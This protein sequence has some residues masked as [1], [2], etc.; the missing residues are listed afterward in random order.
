MAAGLDDGLRLESK[1]QHSRT[2][3]ENHR[4]LWRHARRLLLLVVIGAACAA[5]S[6]VFAQTCG[7]PGQ[8]GNGGAL[9]GVINTYYPGTA[10]AN[11]GATS[12]QLGTSRG[13]ATPIAV[14]NL[15][16][17]M[18]MQDAAIDSDN[19][20]GYGNGTAGTPASGYTAAN[21]VGFYEFVRATNAVPV[22]GGT[23]NI[24][25]TG[26]GTGLLNTYTNAAATA[27][28]GQRRFQVV[29]VPQYTFAILTSGLTAA[30]WNGTTGGILALDAN[31]QVTLGGTV[32][33]NGLG[34]RAGAG[35]QLTGSAGGADTDYRNLASLPF[36][37][38]KG[39][40]IAGTPRFMYNAATGAN[41]DTGVEGYPNGSMARGA[42]GN[43]GG[44]GT[45][46][47]PDVNDE[48]AG[49]G[50]GGNGG[51]GGLGGNSWS[52]NLATGGFGGATF[53]QVATN[54]LV[55]GG[56]GGGGSRNN[57][58]GVAA[59]GS[60]AAGGGI[61]IIRAR[62]IAGTGTITVNGADAFTD[63]LNDG[64]G[65]GGA[66]GSILIST[67][68]GNL[69]GL[70]V[71]ANG[72]RGGDAWRTEP[73]N[74][75]P[76]ERHGPGGGGGGGIIRLSSAAGTLSVT[77]GANG[78]TTTSNSAFGATPGANGASVT[79]ITAAQIPGVQSGAQCTPATAVKLRSFAAVA[80]EDGVVLEW[81]TGFEVDNLGYH[82]YRDDAGQRTRLTPSLVAG[83]AL[84][85][86]A[87]NRLTA[88]FAYSWTDRE[89]K[90]GSQYWLE[91]IDLNGTR[92]LSG[93]VYPVKGNPQDAAAQKMRSPLLSLLATNSRSSQPAAQ[94]AWPAFPL[95][96]PE[97][98]T[99]LMSQVDSL[100]TQ[101]DLA[102]RALVKLLINRD[103]WYRV[104]Q[105]QL[106]QAGL[107][108]N[109]DGRLLHLYTDGVEVPLR[110][111]SSI[112]GAFKP[113]DSIEFYGTRLNTPS[114]DRH[115][116]W[117]A[118]G[119]GIGMRI[120][121]SNLSQPTRPNEKTPS[122]SIKSEQA[123]VPDSLTTGFAET[124]ERR[125]RLIYFS[126]L[127][128]GEEENLFGP[129]LSQ[130]AV[131]QQ[132]ELRHLD[133]TST[134]MAKLEVALQG[135]NATAHMVRVMLNGSEVGAINFANTE[136]TI[137]QWQIP[138]NS[139]REGVNII[140]LIPPGGGTD[141]SLV[142]FVRLTYA[143]K[144][145]AD[146]DL[147]T[148]SVQAGQ[149]IRLGTFSR[150]NVRVVDISVPNQPRE[151]SVQSEPDGQGYA[152]TIQAT[153][154]VRLIA[155]TDQAVLPL[156]SAVIPNLPS[157][158]YRFAPGADQ[159]IITYRD[160]RQSAETLADWRRSQGLAVA[161]I[162]VEDIYDEF[163][164]GA[165]APQGVRDFLFWTTTHWQR[166]PRYVLLVGD[167][168]W[169]PRNQLGVGDF[170]LVPTRLIDTVFMEAAS[171]DWLADF[172]NDG[173]GEMAVGRLPVRNAA[174]ARSLVGKIIAYDAIRLDPQRAAML[175]A[176]NGFETASQEIRALLPSGIPVQAINRADG[177]DAEVR[178]RILNG[179]NGGPRIV[180]YLGHGSVTVW[181]GA[182]LLRTEDAGTLTNRKWPVMVMMT[183]LNAYAHDV[184]IDSL[185]EAM[186][187]ADGGAVAVWASSG[188]TPSVGQLQM[189]RKLYEQLYSST[190][191][192]LGDAIRAA[193]AASQDEDVR[194]TW[195]LLGDPAMKVQ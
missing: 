164:Y 149:T 49:G 190:A 33:L 78:I 13:A 67:L 141:V 158:W 23:V 25:G 191:P 106:A 14:G 26:T 88:G 148:C 121:G 64:A 128:N 37:G 179:I 142:D 111:N 181:T 62:V 174:G 169:D 17:V 55:M 46:G 153:Q 57:T 24:V 172:D 35:A 73:A 173:V 42:P 102:E 119:S 50:G 126:S 109:V 138:Q 151:L 124:V 8:N 160:F 163:S 3:I 193:K 4:N 82:L 80:Y 29:R 110:V 92:T 32:S 66:G 132:L 171:D 52:S 18:Q 44:G 30:A 60:G 69:T 40:G 133:L 155:F 27:T 188:Y 34:F 104:T 162:D 114:T 157:S 152:V 143:R 5:P 56:G 113:G 145:E 161:V 115:V 101:Q 137:A 129:A 103:G 180:N 156:P 38:T 116:Y 154:D 195:V 120:A 45:D 20:D 183:C 36:H 74:G 41:I 135:V 58:P 83:S 68:S 134:S 165:H 84:I 77:G 51:A 12:I 192:R 72:G 186:L 184:Y 98:P 168:T 123:S 176:D 91:D 61:V 48:N 95:D 43:A 7:T 117:L 79:N 150:P 170:D 31:Q 185:G 89:G 54:R 139:L 144:Y 146:G 76:G 96:A 1:N 22:G 90:A 118:V 11:A 2:H 75:T 107:P 182:G 105:E 87:G 93:P 178:E 177:S 39:E 47:N 159:V 130:E 187:K 127:L 28:Q 86:G 99:T 147:L 63:T 136:H 21:N 112:V 194:R 125:E 140:T 59:A 70:T 9:T 122:L 19:D 53:A 16:L 100:E 71:R 94:T 85:A 15:L 175:V 108:P 167:S 81:R 166:V 97:Q 6:Q 189:N 10:T 65:G 131:E